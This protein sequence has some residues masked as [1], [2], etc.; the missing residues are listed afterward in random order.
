MNIGN[1]FKVLM[2]LDKKPPF[3]RADAVSRMSLSDEDRKLIQKIGMSSQELWGK[4]HADTAVMYDR[5]RFYNEVTKAVEHWM[6][7]AA[8]ELYADYATN[9]NQMHNASVWITS[10]NPT[11]QQILT[12]L[13]DDIGIEEKIFDWGWTTAGYGDLFVKVEGMPGVGVVSVNDDKHPVDVSR[14]DNGGSLIGFYETPQGESSGSVKDL[15]PP[16]NYVHFRLLGA[17]RKRPQFTDPSYSEYKTASLMTGADTKQISSS[18]GTS[19]LINALPTY[20]RLR[21]AEDSLLMA[22]LTRGIIRYI[23]KLKVDSGNSEAVGEMLSQIVGTLKRARAL[24]TSGGSPNFDSK[25]NP[26]S[27]V[28]DLL[29]PVW[30][31]TNDLTYDKVGEDA[32]IRWI[33]DIEELRNQLACSLRVPLSVL[34]GFVQESSGQLGSQAI[35][36]LS[37]EFAHSSRRLQRAIKVGIKRLCQIHLAYLNMDPDPRL[38]EVNMSETSTAE[39]ASVRESLDVGADTIRK[40]LDL[41]TEA[42]PNIDKVKVVNYF[43]QKLLKL[44]DFDLNEFHL[45]EPVVSEEQPSETPSSFSETPEMG[46]EAPPTNEVAPEQQ[47]IPSLPNERRVLTEICSREHQRIVNT[48]LTAFLPITPDGKVSSSVL[49]ERWMADWQAMYGNS[50]VKIEDK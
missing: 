12:K 29:I 1:P 7:G 35:E 19:V 28:E 38:F 48:D 31:D 18:Y 14:V 39:E 47:E 8:L 16:W 22:R 4:M 49:N 33:T 5:S 34:G 2:K 27:S 21:L 32:D 43:N 41:A 11:Y 44:E 13:L 30:G 42:D 24:D 17:K 45:A 9:F 26:M 10:Q 20:K 23:W 6:V 40:M 3:I 50:K 15:L 25:F 46:S 37:V 36:K